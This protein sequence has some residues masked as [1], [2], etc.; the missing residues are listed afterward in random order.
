MIQRFQSLFLL[1]AT[2]LMGIFS[3]STVGISSDTIHV[4]VLSVLSAILP[5]ITIFK[6]KNLRLQKKLC[7]ISAL[8]IAA[9]CGAEYLFLAADNANLPAWYQIYLM[10]LISLTSVII[11]WSLINS[12]KKKIESADRLR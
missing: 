12:D 1:L 5:L 2:I 10:P 9:S 4:V 7:C 8:F 11:A 3:F 6:F